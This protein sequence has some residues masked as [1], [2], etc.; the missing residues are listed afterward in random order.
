MQVHT[1]NEFYL[2]D[3]FLMEKL[4]D[5][6]HKVKNNTGTSFGHNTGNRPGE[7]K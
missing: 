1:I 4:T 2:I 3:W 6:C 5:N 7:P